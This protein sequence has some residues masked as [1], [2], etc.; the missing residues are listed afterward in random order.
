MSEIQSK[1]KR[2]DPER[3]RSAILDA[4]EK[5]F[6]KNGYEGTSTNEIAKSADVAVGTIFKHFGDKPTLLAALHR[7]LED[8]FIEAMTKAW[9]S[10]SD[11]HAKFDKMFRALF[12]VAERKRDV[13]PVY[14]MTKELSANRDYWSGEIIVTRIQAL[15]EGGVKEGK[16]AD[17]QTDL[18]AH[19]MHGMVDG[20]MRYWMNNPT[21]KQKGNAI[22]ALVEVS[23]R[24]FL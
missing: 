4:A 18:I 15:Y 24:A 2:F 16:L 19:M 13:M 3:R 7:R 17:H 11:Y 8:E 21:P 6:A 14:T 10:Q 23:K 5:L 22:R 20:A 12:K 9:E 1:K